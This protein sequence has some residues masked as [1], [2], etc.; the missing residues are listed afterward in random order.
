MKT[1]YQKCRFALLQPQK[2]SK[3]EESDPKE[4]ATV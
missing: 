2:V 4:N 1:V 3:K